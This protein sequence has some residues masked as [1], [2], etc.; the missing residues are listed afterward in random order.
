M[1]TKREYEALL[2]AEGLGDIDSGGLMSGRLPDA[3]YVEAATQDGREEYYAHAREFARSGKLRGIVGKVFRLHAEGLTDREIQRELKYTSSK[4]TTK[5]INLGRS[6]MMNKS[7]NSGNSGNTGS[8]R[9]SNKALLILLA[10]TLWE[11]RTPL[12]TR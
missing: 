1:K 9:N 11:T 5:H 4:M 6:A 7:G 8:R 12:L 3:P 2:K 10:E